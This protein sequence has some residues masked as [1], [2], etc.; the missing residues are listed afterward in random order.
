M[1]ASPSRS[2]PLAW[3]AANDNGQLNRLND[4]TD[5]TL[6]KRTDG[7]GDDGI[8]RWRDDDAVSISECE[9]QYFL[10]AQY[11]F[12][13][14]RRSIRSMDCRLTQL[15]C[16]DRHVLQSY[17]NPIFPNRIHEIYI[18]FHYDCMPTMKVAELGPRGCLWT[19]DGPVRRM[20]ERARKLEI[21]DKTSLLYKFPQRIILCAIP[22]LVP[23][24]LSSGGDA[25]MPPLPTIYLQLHRSFPPSKSALTHI[26]V[27]R[28]VLI[29]IIGHTREQTFRST[30][31][32]V[33]VHCVCANV[34][35]LQ[36]SSSSN[37]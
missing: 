3:R 36:S 20:N 19:V 18:Q 35:H 33:R 14:N 17:F 25:R 31:R 28:I 4:G 21:N 26:V 27:C 24:V 2:S 29:R 7:C 16:V 12:D 30:N 1:T 11:C 32:T 34:L 5:G 10:R 13:I 15:K 37:C 9:I 8:H 6:R 22:I 23:D